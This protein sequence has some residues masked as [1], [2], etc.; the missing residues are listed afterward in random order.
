[1]VNKTGRN[2]KCP[3]NSGK[4]YKQCCLRK[5]ELLKVKE[6]EKFINGQDTSSDNVKFVKEYLDEEYFDHKVIDITNDLNVDN[7]K[8]YQVRNY[9]SKVI[10]VAEKTE[11]NQGV[12]TT[13]GPAENDIIVMYRGSYRAFKHDELI[14]VVESIDKMIQTRL[15]G[16]DDK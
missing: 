12:F 6:M 9:E 2:E 3:C 14:N 11:S 13:R 5:D 7:Y 4:K 15:Q 8:I 10:M 16:L 1:M